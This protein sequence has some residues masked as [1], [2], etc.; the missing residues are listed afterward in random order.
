[1]TPEEVLLD[2]LIEQ[3]QVISMLV[4]GSLEDSSEYTIDVDRRG[5]HIHV[6]VSQR[7]DR[8]V[9]YGWELKAIIETFTENSFRVVTVISENSAFEFILRAKDS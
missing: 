5:C 7:G 1:M 2:W 8:T 4:E 6:K 3:E 9:L